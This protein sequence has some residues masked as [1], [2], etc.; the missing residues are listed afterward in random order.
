MTQ[1][2]HTDDDDR[3]RVA[4]DAISNTIRALDAHVAGRD[5]VARIYINLAKANAVVIDSSEAEGMVTEE[6]T[7]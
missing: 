6:R 7:P 1:S 3:L 2:E 4:G 5:D